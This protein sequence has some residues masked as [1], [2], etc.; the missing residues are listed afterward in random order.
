MHTDATTSNRVS[1]APFAASSAARLSVTT[2]DDL[3]SSV[4]RQAL[5]H[6]PLPAEISNEIFSVTKAGDVLE[7]LKTIFLE[8]VST[9]STFFNLWGNYWVIREIK[10]AIGLFRTQI[11]TYSDFAKTTLSPEDTKDVA[12]L[13]TAINEFEKKI[14]DKN[15]DAIR[16]YLLNTIG[17]CFRNISKFPIDISLLL[18]LKPGFLRL[19]GFSGEILSLCSS[20]LVWQ[21]TTKLHASYKKGVRAF[22]EKYQIPRNDCLEKYV[23]VARKNNLSLHPLDAI[24]MS[25]YA[26][27]TQEHESLFLSFDRPFFSLADPERNSVTWID[28]GQLARNLLEKRENEI[29][30]SL[31]KFEQN[32]EIN[33]AKVKQWKSEQFKVLVETYNGLHEDIKKSAKMEELLARL[34][35]E[36][37]EMTFLDDKER[38]KKDQEIRETENAFSESRWKLRNVREKLSV[39][40]NRLNVTSPEELMDFDRW[41]SAQDKNLLIREY[42]DYQQTLN[43]IAFQSSASIIKKKLAIEGSLL[44]FELFK[45]RF[46]VS[47][48]SFC[49]ILG[50]VLTIF[51]FHVIPLVAYATKR[52]AYTATAINLGLL[53][54]SSL[55]NKREKPLSSSDKLTSIPTKWA[56]YQLTR[57]YS[58]NL[59]N[60]TN[61]LKIALVAYNLSSISSRTPYQNSALKQ[62]MQ[63]LDTK[64]NSKHKME[65][66]HKKTRIKLKKSIDEGMDHYLDLGWADFEK[67]YLQNMTLVL[68]NRKKQSDKMA[69]NKPKELSLPDNSDKKDANK[70]KELSLLDRLNIVFSSLDIELQD[71]SQLTDLLKSGIGFDKYKNRTLPPMLSSFFGPPP[72]EEKKLSQTE[73]VEMLIKNLK[74]FIHSDYSQINARM[75]RKTD[76]T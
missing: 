65:E 10:Q 35:K 58:R 34:G 20:I 8:D 44:N 75:T 59:T 21:D 33:L 47:S 70:P 29:T 9:G 49:F 6:S 67:S 38:A 57:E 24:K 2:T 23:E 25:S 43:I 37:S 32:D 42:L 71:V 7:S 46:Q 15:F 54:Y 4:G 55:L 66:L 3:T 72:T 60:Q 62:V 53:A 61:I 73:V 16:T 74:E 31:E 56:Q 48:T 76:A 64:F 41:F 30:A 63:I 17:F 40:E 39:L 22:E 28:D 14:N 69:A 45:S 5:S 50:C 11:Q 13:E 26:R 51:G 1:G 19:V 27:R 68:E 18:Q 36:R 12:S 52:L